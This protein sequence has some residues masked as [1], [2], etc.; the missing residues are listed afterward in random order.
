[1]NPFNTIS[2]IE[3]NVINFLREWLIS[4]WSQSLPFRAYQS[5]PEDGPPFSCPLILNKS[6]ALSRS[7][8]SQLP[9]SNPTGP[10]VTMALSVK[11]TFLSFHL[12][13]LIA[14]WYLTTKVLLYGI[15]QSYLF[16]CFC[17]REESGLISLSSA[18][19]G[20]QGL[21]HAR[22]SSIPSPC[23]LLLIFI[24]IWDGTS[25]QAKLE[26]SVLLL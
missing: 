18:Q 7:L 4:G 14:L 15:H 21:T 10:W 2:E 25:A 17:V 20:T 1:M 8:A 23:T 11:L 26:V 6:E 5:E 12:L 24:V 9:V 22:M 16:S 3:K 13:V 19:D